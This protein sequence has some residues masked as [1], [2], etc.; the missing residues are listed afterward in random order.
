MMQHGSTGADAVRRRGVGDS[1]PP[2]VGLISIPD[3]SLSTRVDA[4]D[5][6]FQADALLGPMEPPPSRTMAVIQPDPDRRVALG[7]EHIDGRPKVQLEVL[8]IEEAERR[9]RMLQEEEEA[10]WTSTLGSRVPGQVINNRTL[11]RDSGE[12]PRRRLGQ[13]LKHDCNPA[14]PRLL[15]THAKIWTFDCP[16]PPIHHMTPCAL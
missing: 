11:L 16:S 14:P 1:D 12:G 10:R 15:A 7:D 6:K 2:S 13:C 9:E 5:P 4:R 3:P 8:N